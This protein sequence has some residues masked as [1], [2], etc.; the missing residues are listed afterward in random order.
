LNCKCEK[1]SIILLNHSHT[2]SLPKTHTYSVRERITPMVNFINIIRA[3][4]LAPKFRTKNA[5]VKYWWNRHLQSSKEIPQ[6]VRMTLCLEKINETV[7]TVWSKYF[8][9][10]CIIF[11]WTSTILFFFRIM[12]G[13]VGL[14]SSMP[15]TW[16]WDDPVWLNRAKKEHY[17]SGTKRA[18]FIKNQSFLLSSILL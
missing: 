10:M 2:S 6:H 17:S 4:F 3:H 7:E 18:T 11:K 15:I 12:I 5:R 8:G 16:Y 9:T 14:S 13:F 1:K